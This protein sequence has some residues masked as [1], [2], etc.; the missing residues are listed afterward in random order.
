MIL[1]GKSDAGMKRKVNQD[2]FAV[3]EFAENA[4]LVVVC[5]GMGGNAG[6]GEASRIAAGSFTE[7]IKE[8][9]SSF[10]KKDNKIVPRGENIKKALD[11]ALKKA[12]A[13]VH[14]AAKSNAELSG[15]G[16]TLV[17]ALF[18]DG[19][20]YSVNVGDSRL[21]MI[22][23]N[24]IKQLTHDHSYVQF[25]VDLGKISPEE[26]RSNAHKNIITR[27]VGTEPEIEPDIT[28]HDVPTDDGRYFLLCSDGLTN[29]VDEAEI[30]RIVT[31]ALPLEIK[32]K[33]L[34]EKANGNGGS[35]NITVVVL[36]SGR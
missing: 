28:A 26:A 3:L 29:M 2:S 8:F 4:T 32:V 1:C 31:D 34:I 25:L 17:A 22:D 35:D 13:A 7:S 5:D 19:V 27:A 23:K 14:G 36:E 16:T 10:E 9:L 12:N 20:L 33:A 30:H 21:Y 6:G 15:M 18:L 24:E 11:K